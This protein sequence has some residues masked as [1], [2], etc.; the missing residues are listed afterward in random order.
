MVLLISFCACVGLV[1]GTLL[2]LVSQAR[3]W[4]G[5]ARDG[6]IPSQ[7]A[8]VNSRTMTPLLATCVG[9][10]LSIGLASVL[11]FRTLASMMSLGALLALTAVNLSLICLRHQ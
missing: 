3:V 6:L 7:F 5:L 2:N 8:T 9:G 11:E 10:L 4:M 1:S